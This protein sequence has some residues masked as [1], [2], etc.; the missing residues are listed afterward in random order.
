MKKS[1]C[2][3]TVA[4]ILGIILL[5]KIAPMLFTLI[6]IGLI[7][8]V[9]AVIALVVLALAIIVPLI[10]FGGYMQMLEALT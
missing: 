1:G 3:G 8:S 5:I 4:V 9:V 7:L 10:A 2:F 6:K